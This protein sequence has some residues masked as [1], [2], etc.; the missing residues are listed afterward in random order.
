M[1]FDAFGK[2]SAKSLTVNK[3]AA[4]QGEGNITSTGQVGKGANKGFN[5]E[6]RIKGNNNV[7]N[8]TVQS[9]DAQVA[10]AAMSSNIAALQAN[11]NVSIAAVNQSADTAKLAML[12]NA[13]VNKS[14][15]ALSES[16]INSAHQ[17]TIASLQ[18]AQNISRSHVDLSGDAL[19]SAQ[20][21]AL[22]ATPTDPGYFASQQTKLLLLF[23]VVALAIAFGPKLFKQ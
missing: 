12:A 7:T 20:E 8:V 10:Q 4:V 16:A 1:A 23:G 3:Q 2:K 14:S 15:L 6:G 9:L 22:T 11:Q 17:T 5:Y 21:I 18:L 19:S 13:D